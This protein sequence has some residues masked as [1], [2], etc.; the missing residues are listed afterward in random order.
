MLLRKNSLKLTLLVAFAFLFQS[1][2]LAQGN[3]FSWNNDNASKDNIY[4]TWNKNTPESEMKDDIKALAEYG[5]TIKY[6]NVK[7]N[8]KGEITAIK[9]EYFDKNGNKGSMQLDNLNPINTIKFYKQGD[10]VG[11]GEPSVND[12][13]ASNDFF[14]NFGND[15][16]KQFNFN[17]DNDSLQPQKF[18]FSFPDGQSFG[19][20]KSKIIIKK[21]G[22]KPLV[23]EDG[24]VIEGAED[25][26]P[27][28]IE[29]IKKNNRVEGIAN[30]QSFNFNFDSDSMDSIKEQMERMQNMFPNSKGDKIKIERD[31]KSN[32]DDLEKTKDEMLKAKE[33]M[34]KAKEE[35]QNAKKELE[36]AK[37][38]LKTQKA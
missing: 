22:K 1:N 17:F 2:L 38:S 37:S 32:D 33:E 9:M 36:K 25:Y 19:Q 4:M 5:V 30:G 3:K 8:S 27:E 15:R 7:R 6:S 14:N 29:E 24:E 21:D 10:E 11:F 12:M 34:L 31:F 28:E 23:I 13:I 35:M 18:N 16:M 26:T 20:S